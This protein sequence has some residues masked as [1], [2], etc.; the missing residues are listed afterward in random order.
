MFKSNRRRRLTPKPTPV[1][2]PGTFYK[3]KAP[4]PAVVK[5]VALWGRGRNRGVDYEAIDP[6]L[7]VRNCKF[8]DFN[9][10]IAEVLPTAQE[11]A[12]K[13]LDNL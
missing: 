8:A 9:H 13:V 10:G 2:R 11:V 7:P 1:A 4:W 12:D 5:V 3:M 6:P